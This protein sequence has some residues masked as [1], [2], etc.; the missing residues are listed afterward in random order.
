MAWSRN[1]RITVIALV[2]AVLTL[3]AAWLVVPE[4]RK[5]IG[6][7]RVEQDQLGKTSISGI[8]VDRDTNQGIGQASISLAGRTE[9]YVTE[10]SG[11]FRI[12]LPQGSPK[13]IRL[14]VSKSGFRP[15][16]TSVE[17]P[18]DNLVLPLRR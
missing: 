9:Q 1:D 4:F 13:R 12:D 14:H 17:P 5:W 8:V 7:D 11:N 18:A 16:D 3:G 2:V 10:D 6:L 15:F